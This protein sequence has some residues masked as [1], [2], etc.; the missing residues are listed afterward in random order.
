MADDAN[1][2]DVANSALDTGLP[3]IPVASSVIGDKRFQK[4]IPCDASGTPTAGI[5][6]DINLAEVGGAAVTL[7]QKAEASSIPVVLATEQDTAKATN[8]DA[9][10]C[11]GLATWDAFNLSW[12]PFPSDSTCIPIVSVARD[13]GGAQAQLATRTSAPG[14]SEEGLITRNIPSGTQAVSGSVSV[15]ASAPVVTTGNITAIAQT[16]TRA[17]AGENSVTF[18]IRGTYGSVAIIFE[19]SLDGT[20]WFTTQACRTDANTVETAS[21]TISNTSRAWEA[22][23]NGMHSFRVRAT[24]WASGTAAIQINSN[25]SAIEPVPAIAT[26]A[27]TLSST[28]LTSVVPGTAATNLGKAIDS[29]PGA[30]DTG[31]ANLAQRVDIPGVLTPANGDYF[32]LRGNNL[33]QLWVAAVQSGTWSVNNADGN[34]NKLIQSTSSPA[35]TDGGLNVRNMPAGPATGGLPVAVVLNTATLTTIM[36]ANTARKYLYIYNTTANEVGVRLSSNTTNPTI[37]SIRLPGFGS[38]QSDLMEWQGIVQAIS[39]TAASTVH[40]SEQT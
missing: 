22:S 11:T 13:G 10:S 30:T 32:L 29:V 24:A 28:T 9:G 3:R 25:S 18:S 23:V 34:G 39:Y 20:N 26:H 19:V 7:G 8:I 14:G 17:L 40:V 15:L 37:N 31:I 1:G 6:Q 35:A 38:W 36:A 21:G 33:G 27:V 12:H 16:V 5:T 2:V 4:V